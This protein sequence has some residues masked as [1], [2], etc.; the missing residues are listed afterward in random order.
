ERARPPLGP[1]LSSSGSLH[2]IPACA[3]GI[4]FALAPTDAGTLVGSRV[5]IYRP[6]QRS[7]WIAASRI[8]IEPPLSTSH[9]VRRLALPRHTAGLIFCDH[10]TICA[11][12][13][14]VRASLSAGTVTRG[15]RL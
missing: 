9:S 15:R 10:Q 12:L 7:R 1:V 14:A 13:A 5:G 11:T 3:A 4:G 8:T 2:R 6:S